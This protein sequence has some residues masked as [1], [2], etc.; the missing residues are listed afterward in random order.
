MKIIKKL[1]IIF[2]AL[3]LSL[4]DISFFST[5]LIG[6]ATILS[7]FSFVVVFAILEEEKDFLFFSAAAVLFFSIF[8]SLPTWFIFLMFFLIPQIVLYLRKIFIPEILM[9]VAIL[10]FVCMNFIFEILLLISYRQLDLNGLKALIYFVI[11]NTVFSTLSFYLVK[12][13]RKKIT[14]DEIKFN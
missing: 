8:S 6:N 3:C 4:L 11:V 2:F 7:L 13:I 12:K 1:L 10:Y 14:I 5:I 9:P